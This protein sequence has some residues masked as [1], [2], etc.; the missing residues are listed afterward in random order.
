LVLTIILRTVLVLTVD[1]AQLQRAITDNQ[2]IS[3]G[4]ARP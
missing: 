2:T 3:P 4:P 1:A